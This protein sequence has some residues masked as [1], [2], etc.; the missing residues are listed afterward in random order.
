MRR[1]RAPVREQ[2][3][4]ILVTI[5]SLISAPAVAGRRLDGIRRLRRCPRLAEPDE[6]GKLSGPGGAGGGR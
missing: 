6:P 4:A 3:L 5:A 1:E 2:L